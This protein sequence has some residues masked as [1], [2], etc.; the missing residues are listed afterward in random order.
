MYKTLNAVNLITNKTKVQ[1][2]VQEKVK[3]FY[4]LLGI[5]MLK[6]YKSTIYSRIM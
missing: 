2:I 4:I 6:C 5:Y 3:V 1:L